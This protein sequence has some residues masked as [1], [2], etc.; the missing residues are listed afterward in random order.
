MSDDDHRTHSI[1]A[2]R[3]SVISVPKHFRDVSDTFI[4]AVRDLLQNRGWDG[5]RFVSDANVP[6]IGRSWELAAYMALLGREGTY[7]G[8]IDGYGA[9]AHVGP[10]EDLE[11][12]ESF[13]S[14]II[15]PLYHSLQLLQTSHA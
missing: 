13:A 2:I 12:K 8:S 1:K 14:D 9:N 5:V 7:T 3:D 4:S 11:I 15:Y 6:I 10:V